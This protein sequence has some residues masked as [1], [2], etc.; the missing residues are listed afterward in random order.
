MSQIAISAASISDGAI[1]IASS[2]EFVGGGFK[3]SGLAAKGSV[4][5]SL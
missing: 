1:K 5:F 3:N 4:S 2:A